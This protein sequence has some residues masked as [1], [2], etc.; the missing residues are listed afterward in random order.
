[1]K[2]FTDNIYGQ[3]SEF[4]LFTIDTDLFEH[5]WMSCYWEAVGNMQQDKQESWILLYGHEGSRAFRL[6]ISGSQS[7]NLWISYKY[8]IQETSTCRPTIKVRSVCTFQVSGIFLNKKTERIKKNRVLSRSLNC[9]NCDKLQNCR[10]SGNL[11]STD[12][13]ELEFC[14]GVV[15]SHPLGSFRKISEK[16][17]LPERPETLGFVLLIVDIWS[18]LL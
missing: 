18:G 7:D 16:Q 10:F 6:L 8:F 14:V 11:G 5:A 17:I 9:L 1:M 4:V 12:C 2:V 13:G 3:Y 15:D